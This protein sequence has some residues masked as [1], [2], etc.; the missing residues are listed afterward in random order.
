MEN[1]KPMILN[2]TNCK[3]IAKLHGSPEVEDW[4][5]K[6]IQIYATTTKVAGETGGMP[7]H[8]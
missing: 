5:G 4:V 3:T 8:T 6:K 1:E 7:A 2:R